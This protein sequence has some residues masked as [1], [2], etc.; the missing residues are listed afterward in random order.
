MFEGSGKM[1]EE[2]NAFEVPCQ[3][4]SMRMSMSPNQCIEPKLAL[5]NRLTNPTFNTKGRAVDQGNQF[6]ALF[7]QSNPPF[8]KSLDYNGIKVIAII[9]NER[10][11]FFDKKEFVSTSKPQIQDLN[12]RSSALASIIKHFGDEYAMTPTNFDKNKSLSRF[13]ASH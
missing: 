9:E 2:P 5:L 10:A 8:R 11:Y 12:K 1:D 6:V 3:D 7:M 4:F 13:D